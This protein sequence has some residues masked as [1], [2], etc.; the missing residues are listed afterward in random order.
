MIASQIV[1]ASGQPFQLRTPYES[2]TQSF[3]SIGWHSPSLGP[4]ATLSSSL[5]T[6]RNR[7]RAAY[8]NSNLM[9]G[10]INKNTANEVG[11]GFTLRSLCNDE[12]FRQEANKLWK[13]SADEMDPGGIL[14]FAGLQALMVRNRR[15]SG[16]VFIRLRRR[17]TT[18]GLAVPMQIDVLEADC[19]PIEKHE[20]LKNG[21]KIRNG[22]EFRGPHRVAYWVYKEH[23][24]DGECR[25]DELVRIP[26][27]DMIHHYLPIR[28]GQIR[29][30]PEAATALLKDHTF[31]EY[32][33]SELVR[34]KERSA[35]TGFLYRESHDDEEYGLPGDYSD[36]EP[37][38][39]AVRIRTGYMLRGALNEKLELFDGDNTGQGYADFMRWQSLQLS[40]GLSIP[41]PLLTGDWSGLNDRL[42]RAMLNE[43]RREIEMCQDHLMAFQVC[44]QVWQWWM[45]TAILTGKLSAPKYSQD[46]AFYQALDVCPDAWKYLHPVQ[47]VQARQQAI[48]SNLSNI[49]SEASELGYDVDDN[50]RRN[51]KATKK[52][53]E[54]C[55]KEGVDP[56]LY[57]S[58]LLA[59]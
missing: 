11:T 41:Y 35:Y 55:K 31:K 44:R 59:C 45:D 18:S 24:E 25:Q 16:E 20:D 37:T 4:N 8:R 40:S 5:Y 1:D 13:L 29:G 28:P 9:R 12:H 6:L 57:Q 54:I 51:A 42:V 3:R 52:F 50:M 47:D 53:M 2:A 43:Y 32:D 34:K 19:I 30:E 58:C 46:K 10:A 17:K 27:R 56:Q 23:P 33:D 14:N 26:A 48:S 39:E 22:I 38:G 21:N 49:D 36:D 15:L 7:T